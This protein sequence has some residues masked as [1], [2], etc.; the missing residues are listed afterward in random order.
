MFAWDQ[1]LQE[2]RALTT[3]FRYVHSDCFHSLSLLPFSDVKLSV[4]YWYDV[5]SLIFF[6]PPGHWLDILPEPNV[7]DCEEN[8]EC[9]SEKLC[10]HLFAEQLLWCNF[11]F[12]ENNVSE[13]LN[14][15]ENSFVVS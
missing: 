4:S 7:V 13:Q 6:L 2:L 12:R 11:M 10:T 15:G 9:C 14:Q 8:Q 3:A 5:T 1:R